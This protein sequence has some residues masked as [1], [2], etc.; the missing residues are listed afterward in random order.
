[1]RS[2]FRYLLFSIL[3]YC[4]L[5]SWVYAVHKKATSGI[6][7]P[8][9]SIFVIQW[10]VVAVISLIVYIVRLV[11]RDKDKVTFG[12]VFLGV[13]DFCNAA[14]GMIMLSEATD[15]KSLLSFWC[16]M[17]ATLILSLLISINIFY[18]VS[19]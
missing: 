13:T 15:P 12:Y 6:I 8:A 10:P 3:I 11:R 7:D 19:S 2:P 14:I 9:W 4:A 17:A 1:M 5:A 16:A 18:K